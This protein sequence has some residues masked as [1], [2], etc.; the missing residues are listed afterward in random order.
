M[1]IAQRASDNGL[2]PGQFSVWLVSKWLAG[3]A[4]RTLAAAPALEIRE[5]IHSRTRNAHDQWETADLDDLQYLATAGVNTDVLV[6]QRASALP[7][8]QRPWCYSPCASQATSYLG[9]ATAPPLLDGLTLCTVLMPITA[10][11]MRD[12]TSERAGSASGLLQTTQQR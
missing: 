3:D 7:Y 9:S 5:V 6:A 8:K 2:S 11:A 10:L 1:V 4:D 12:V